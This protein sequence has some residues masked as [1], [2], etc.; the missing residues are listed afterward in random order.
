MASGSKLSSNSTGRASSSRMVIN[1]SQAPVGLSEGRRRQH[2]MIGEKMHRCQSNQ[3]LG[4]R[5]DHN[6]ARSPTC[7]TQHSLMAYLIEVGVL[8]PPLPGRANGRVTT[9]IYVPSCVQLITWSHCSLV[10]SF[11]VSAACRVHRI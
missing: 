4:S 8:Q 11:R 10:W 2:S 3:P 9:L 5:H 7:W 1:M 6:R